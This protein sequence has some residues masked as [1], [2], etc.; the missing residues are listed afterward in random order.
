MKRSVKTRLLLFLLMIG[1]LCA[2]V[3]C[4]AKEKP[5]MTPVYGKDVK[6]GSYEV[7]VDSSSSMFR[8]VKAELRVANGSMTAVL[9][10]SG[11]GYLKLFMGTGEE[12][13]NAGE[14]SYIPYVEDSEG[15]YT[16]TI[17][18]EALD[19]EF[20][21]AAFSKR[22]ER[23]YDRKLVV[24]SSSL[25]DEALENVDHAGR[26]TAKTK[27]SELPPVEIKDKDGDYTVEITLE[28]GTG[29]ADVTSPVSIHVS[30]GTAV[31]SLEWS[32]PFYDYM[33][34]N[35]IQY[36]PVNKEGNSVFEIPVLALDE[37][38]DVI[39]DTTAMSTPHEIEY[40]LT[41]HADTLKKETEDPAGMLLFGAAAVAVAAVV[42]V[43]FV[44]QKKKVRDA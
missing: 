7:E 11:V 18:V 12:A 4:E 14:E 31:A 41:F 2:P 3:V 6:D 5:E 28:G 8:V 32:S 23:W 38:I 19:Q 33:Y 21:C 30:E 36:F 34:V 29:R 16:Y 20:D 37:A 1:V 22:K 44:K 13:L 24:L 42:L 26:E 35:G 40:K 27:N 9:T 39:A 43:A 10:L 17:P 15:K 25:P